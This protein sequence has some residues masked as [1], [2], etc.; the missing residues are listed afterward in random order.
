MA[1]MPV[2]EFLRM[3]QR[4]SELQHPN[5]EELAGCCVEH[6]Q[7]LLVYK[8]FSDETLDDMIHLKKL[9][10]SDD[11]AAKITLPWDARVAVALEAAKALEYAIAMIIF[12]LLNN[13]SVCLAGF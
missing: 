2:D 5:I 6:G 1:R 11:P 9:A 10:S 13:S 12:N 3:V 4:I 7:R 8:H